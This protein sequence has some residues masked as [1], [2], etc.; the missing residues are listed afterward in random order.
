VTREEVR[1]RI[2]EVGIV[3]AIRVTSAEDAL[4]AAESVSRL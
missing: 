4:F 3:P 2:E 1:T